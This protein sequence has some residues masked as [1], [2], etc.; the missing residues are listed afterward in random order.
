M[1]LWGFIILAAG[2]L[3]ALGL[4]LTN[5]D[6]FARMKELGFAGY[7]SEFFAVENLEAGKVVFLIAV[8]AAI[9][10]LVVYLV[11]RAK[12]KEEANPVIPTKVSKFFRDVRGEF[13]KIVWPSFGS[14]ARNTG[15]VLAACAVTAVVIVMVDLGLGQL[16]ALLMNL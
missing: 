11:G 1:I 2:I 12:N 15:V 9:V 3:T 10:G 7:V 5:L 16:V 13:K 14:V 4:F 8:A 6:L